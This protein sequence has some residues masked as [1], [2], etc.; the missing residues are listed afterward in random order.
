MCFSASNCEIQGCVTDHI[1]V[2][3]HENSAR[4]AGSLNII[5]YG[6][7]LTLLEDVNVI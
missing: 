7:K 3:R 6:E 2:P 4:C 5:I 1:T